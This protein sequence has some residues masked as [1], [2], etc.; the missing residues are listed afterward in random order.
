M[1]Q[2]S[3]YGALGAMS[4]M[5]VTQSAEVL[6]RGV[7]ALKNNDQIKLLISS[8]NVEGIDQALLTNLKAS[9]L[10]GKISKTEAKEIVESFQEIKG[11]INSMP[12]DMSIDNKSVALDLMI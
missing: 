7:N 3:Y 4:V 10:S 12:D 9:I 6:S 2:E 8:A 11:K 1:L 5:S